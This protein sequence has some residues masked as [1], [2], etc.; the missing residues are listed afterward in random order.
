MGKAVATLSDLSIITSDNPRSEPPG[1]IIRDIETGFIA[2]D[3]QPIGKDKLHQTGSA[4]GYLKVEDR[5]EAIGLAIQVARPGDIILIA[6]K[7]HETYQILADRKLPFDDRAEV[8]KAL[9]KT[10]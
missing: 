5:R 6:G 9:L 3:G 8:R 4:V 10:P 7:G 1:D 2:E